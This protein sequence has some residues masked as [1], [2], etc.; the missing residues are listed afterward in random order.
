MT[1]IFLD[2]PNS[3][4]CLLVQGKEHLNLFLNTQNNPETREYLA[5]YLPL[6]REDEEEWIKKAVSRDNIHLAV[7]KKPCKTPI[8]SM[9]LH[10]IDWKNRHATTGAVLTTSHWGK[11]YGSDAKMLLLH[12]AFFEL[13]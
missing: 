4:A 9:G 1:P 10:H 11:G 13:G 12:Y 2:H 5:R 6:T 7:A 3:S 8:G